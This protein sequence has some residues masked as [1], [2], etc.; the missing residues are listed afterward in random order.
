MVLRSR[1]TR[2]ALVS[3]AAA[4]FGLWYLFLYE[5]SYHGLIK[6]ATRTLVFAHRGF[7]NYAPDNSLSG[8]LL[9]MQAGMDGVDMDGQLSADGELVIF[10]DLSVDRLTESTGRVNSK[11]LRDLLALDLGAKYGHGFKNTFVATFDDFVRAIKGKG[12]L[13]VELKVPGLRDTGIE[14]KAVAI[15]RKYD[16]QDFVYLSSFNPIVL[17][18][19]KQLDRAIRTVYIFMDTNWNKQLLAEIRAEDR[20]NLPWVLRKEF[21]RRAIRK[22]IHPDLLSVNYQVD[23]RTIGTLLRRGY[24]IFL[25]TPEEERD[26]RWALAKR[27][28]GVI[29]DEPQLAKQLRDRP[30]R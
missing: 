28:Y 17:Y 22:L 5:P 26:L 20:V 10:H 13:M 4:L 14:Q 16:A 1:R 25:W 21:F 29:S 24:P 9:A 11:T 3:T 19:L 12:I 6:P 2:V 27:P 8:A 30:A 23:E 18:R 7:G 15:I